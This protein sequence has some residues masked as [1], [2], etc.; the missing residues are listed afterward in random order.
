MLTKFFFWHLYNSKVNYKNGSSTPTCLL[1]K[2][3]FNINADKFSKTHSNPQQSCFC[4]N[5]QFA[6]T[7]SVHNIRFNSAVAQQKM[8]KGCS[9][10]L[11]L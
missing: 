4:N 8:K 1:I 2:F 5:Q 9:G 10:K 3:I 6:S 7:M 11:L